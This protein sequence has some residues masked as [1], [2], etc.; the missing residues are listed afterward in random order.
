M[1]IIRNYQYPFGDKAAIQ[2][3][4]WDGVVNHMPSQ[5]AVY[6]LSRNYFRQQ[7]QHDGTVSL[8]EDDSVQQRIANLKSML[9]VTKAADDALAA[10]HIVSLYLPNGGRGK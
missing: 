6:L 1:N 9:M 2:K 8:L 10:L 5:E 4:I 7:Q 3:M